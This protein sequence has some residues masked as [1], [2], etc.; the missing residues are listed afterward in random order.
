V[1]PVELQS[2]NSLSRVISET[3]QSKKVA[4]RDF[5]KS[6]VNFARLPFFAL[7]RYQLESKKKVEYKDVVNRGGRTLEVLWKVT[8][9]AEYGYPGPFDKKVHKAVEYLISQSGLSR[10]A[11]SDRVFYL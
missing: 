4:R 7:S 3:E 11:F 1:K 5:I 6:E 9:N 2:E 8:A 10:K